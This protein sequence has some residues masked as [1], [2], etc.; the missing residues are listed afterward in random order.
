MLR[1]LKIIDLI[2]RDVL[3]RKPL[4]MLNRNMNSSVITK[5]L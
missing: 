5:K 3:I 4:Y 1:F 2:I